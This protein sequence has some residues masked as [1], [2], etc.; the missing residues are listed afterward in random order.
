MDGLELLTLDAT[1]SS[2][3]VIVCSAAILDLRAHESMLKKYGIAVL[4]KPFDIATLYGH[5]EEALR[6]RPAGG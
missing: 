4:P 3:P 2:I 1:T 5:V 6:P